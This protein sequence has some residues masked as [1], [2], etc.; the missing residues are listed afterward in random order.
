M[1]AHVFGK[2]AWVELF[3]TAGLDEATMRRWHHE[4]EARWPADHERFL[5]WLGETPAEI[6]RIRAAARAAAPHP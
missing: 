6:A 3:R 5:A 2:Q 4:F 1:D